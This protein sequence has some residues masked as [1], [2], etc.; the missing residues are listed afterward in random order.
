MVVLGAVSLRIHIS[1]DAEFEKGWQAERGGDLEGAI[2]H[3]RRA[4]SWRLLGSSYFQL[5]IARLQSM[6]EKAT[7]QN[8]LLIAA[9]AQRAIMAALSASRW[10]IKPLLSSSTGLTRDI[11]GIENTSLVAVTGVF[12][13]IFSMIRIC[14]HSFS[15]N[16]FALWKWVLF[17]II[18][19]VA[20]CSGLLI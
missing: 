20:L 1:A 16:H 6:A 2:S 9:L 4:A 8:D 3:Y 14:R 17:A 18:G 15:Q 10:G 5:S 7:K 19:I 11:K 13:F 12:V